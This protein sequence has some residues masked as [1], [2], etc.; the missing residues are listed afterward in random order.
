MAASSVTTMVTS[1]T[2]PLLRRKVVKPWPPSSVDFSTDVYDAVVISDSDTHSLPGLSTTS[3]I[4]RSDSTIMYQNGTT[5]TNT[6]TAIVSRRRLPQ[7]HSSM[8]SC[9]RGRRR[10]AGVRPVAVPAGAAP[11]SGTATSGALTSS[12]P[13]GRQA[14][15]PCPHLRAG[16]PA[17]RASSLL[18]PRCEP[19][20]SSALRPL[21]PAG[22]PQV[23]EDHPGQHHGEHDRLRG[24]Q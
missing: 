4:G 20:R 19:S 7:T 21:G 14:R 11:V 15:C 8:L 22:G 12:P 6:R 23:E 10:V 5:V 9:R 13:A 3:W 1:A 17:G 16:Q 18:G 2:K 24:G